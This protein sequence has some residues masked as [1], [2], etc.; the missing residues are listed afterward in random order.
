MVLGSY[1]LNFSV[2]RLNSEFLSRP[3]E[4]DVITVFNTQYSVLFT[5][6][7]VPLW[8]DSPDFFGHD[9]S[10]HKALYAAS[11]TK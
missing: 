8:M 5:V 9:C 7:T 4:I 10:V 11:D 1:Y 2:A 3:L 6:L